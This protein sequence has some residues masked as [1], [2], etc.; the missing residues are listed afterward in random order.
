ML[1]APG[2]EL[3]S[4]NVVTV[5]DCAKCILENRDMI[6]GVKVRLSDSIAD[7]GKNEAEAYRQVHGKR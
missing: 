2:G 6:V 1:A 3:D 4:L 7:N 5:D